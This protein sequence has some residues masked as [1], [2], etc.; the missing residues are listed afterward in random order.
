MKPRKALLATAAL[1]LSATLAFK[2]TH[3]AR[4]ESLRLS[5]QQN[6]TR[7][8]RDELRSLHAQA[9]WRQQAPA[10]LAAWQRSGF[11]APKDPLRADECLHSMRKRHNLDLHWQLS[12]I[13]TLKAAPDYRLL[14]SP[15]RLEGQDM[16]LDSLLAGIHSLH[17]HAC[18]LAVLRQVDLK[19]DADGPILQA[20]LE[21]VTVETLKHAP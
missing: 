12:P 16:G 1:L 6:Q 7:Q 14:S 5:H 17:K 8:L 4:S 11:F 18:A 20:R 3:L 21:F 15:V 19:A 9:P 10:L 2:A 13:Q